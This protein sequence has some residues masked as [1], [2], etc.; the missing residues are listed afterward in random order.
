MH[1]CTGSWCVPVTG[2]LVGTAAETV[3][4]A[5]SPDDDAAGPDAIGSLA[6]RD[7]VG[8]AFRRLTHDQ[9]AVLILFYYADLPLIDVA[10]ALDIPIGTTKSR[11]S[12]ATDALRAA[13]ETDERTPELVNGWAR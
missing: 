2:P 7:R 12:R 11:L 3:E 1:G 4:I 10:A 6:E 8:R 5:L 13:L 9:R